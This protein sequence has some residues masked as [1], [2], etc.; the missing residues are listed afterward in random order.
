MF[1]CIVERHGAWLEDLRR[2][3]RVM[4][5]Q[6]PLP[7]IPSERNGTVTAVEI[8]QNIADSIREEGIEFEYSPALSGE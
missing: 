5:D 6:P 7:F 4:Q 8:F 1:I 3:Q 2:M